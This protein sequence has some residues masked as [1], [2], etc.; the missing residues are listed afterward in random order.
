MDVWALT[1]PVLLATDRTVMDVADGSVEQ[2]KPLSAKGMG[3]IILIFVRKSS[4]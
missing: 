1:V 4:A 2:K 3:S